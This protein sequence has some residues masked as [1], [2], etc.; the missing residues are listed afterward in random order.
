MSLTIPQTVRQGGQ[1]KKNSSTLPVTLT[2]FISLAKL[3]GTWDLNS[4][5]GART[6]ALSS[7][8]PRWKLRV[9]TTGSGLGPS[10]KSLSH[11][12][13]Y[14]P[15]LHFSSR[16]LLSTYCVL[17]NAGDTTKLSLLFCLEHSV[18]NSPV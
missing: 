14:L 10:R 11:L 2:I 1:K 4:T 13:F 8:S 12:D 16:C 17:L 5:A 7:P 18:H 15:P 9:P 6:C 3:H